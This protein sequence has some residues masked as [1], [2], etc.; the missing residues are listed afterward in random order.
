MT[1]FFCF[2]VWFWD[3]S[4]FLP[5]ALDYS[6]SK[7]RRISI[8]WIN[9]SIFSGNNATPPFLDKILNRR[10]IL[11]YNAAHTPYIYVH[12]SI[13]ISFIKSSAL[14]MWGAPF[15]SVLKVV[16]QVKNLPA[17]AGDTGSVPG[18]E[19]STCHGQPSLWTTATEPLLYER[20]SYHNE[21]PI[22]HNEE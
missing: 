8:I 13:W 12:I 3:W 4:L 17:G 21:K 15:Q 14:S 2:K 22:H 20:R 5:I 6:L 16:C 18:Q 19:D 9:Y 10:I 11:L 1:A 7:L